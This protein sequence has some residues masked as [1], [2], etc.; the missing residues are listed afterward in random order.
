MLEVCL[1]HIADVPLPLTNVRFEGKN[2]HDSGGTPFPLMT[3]S[4]LL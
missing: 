2:G 4:G 1:W 3:H